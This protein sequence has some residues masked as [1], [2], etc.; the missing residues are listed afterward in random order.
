MHGT[1]SC[2]AYSPSVPLLSVFPELPAEENVYYNGI[3]HNPSGR[4][5]ATTS[6]LSVLVAD[7]AVNGM[8]AVPSRPTSGTQSV[9]G[10]MQQVR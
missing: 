4:V 7:E 9:N 1:C 5:G 3:T 10:R 6:S 8:T 2:L